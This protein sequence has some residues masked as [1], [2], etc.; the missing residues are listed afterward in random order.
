MHPLSLTS[1]L[2]TANVISSTITTNRNSLGEQFAFVEDLI[3]D[4]P[5]LLRYLGLLVARLADAGLVSL[6][7]LP[8]L[9]REPLAAVKHA[10]R[11]AA[12]TVLA[13]ALRAL[14]A[15][16]GEAAARLALEGVDV[17]AL[18]FDAPG[19][20]AAVEEWVVRNDFA[21]LMAS[22]G[23]ASAPESPTDRLLAMLGADAPAE[24]IVAWCKAEGLGPQ[25]P[26]AV[27][28][29]AHAVF[30]HLTART[31]F[32]DGRDATS[33]PDADDFNAQRDILKRLAPVLNH[34]TGEDPALQLRLLYAA[35]KFCAEHTFPTGAFL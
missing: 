6:A 17:A 27:D 11:P 7:A 5:D 34:V 32:A 33:A 18:W 21:S 28:L 23:E 30:A 16:H 19:T 24:R 14:T 13:E 31:T 29:V 15:A 8:A 4:T 3:I 1:R 2:K 22:G 20:D 12:P 26:G 25:T 9:M 35:Q 10:G